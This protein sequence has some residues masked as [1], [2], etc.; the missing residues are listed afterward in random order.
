[1][2]RA[3]VPKVLVGA[4]LPALFAVPALG[5]VYS[6][7]YLGYAWETGG[8]LPSDAGD[9]LVI[10]SVADYVDPAFGVDLGIDELTFH[11]Y[12]LVSGGET[13]F[14]GNTMI[15]YAGGY[16]EIYQDP[17]R[18]ADWGVNPPN[19]TA[20]GSFT[21]GSLFFR[22]AFTAF[23]L[24]FDPS[25]SYG[26]FEGTLDGLAGSIIDDVCSDCVY[27]WGGA[28]TLD[29]G[30]QIP[31]G[32]DLQIDGVFEIDAAVSSESASWGSVKALFNN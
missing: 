31:Q 2:K 3:F 27:T 26:S 18:N 30:A 29:A 21:E 16:L 8:I 10:V 19:A 6:V 25:G 22:G 4:L 15:N 24:F 32:Y 14:L 11:V 12:G 13:D 7:D 17:S 1:M 28:F 9:E 20:P 5:Q 23:T